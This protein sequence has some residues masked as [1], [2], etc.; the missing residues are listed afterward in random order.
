M[1]PQSIGGVAEFALLDDLAPA[2]RIVAGRLDGLPSDGLDGLRDHLAGGGSL[3]IA[4]EPGDAVAAELAGAAVAREHPAAEWFVTLEACPE[5]IRLDRETPVSSTLRTLTPV[6]DAVSVAATTNIAM[7]H[8]PVITVRAVGAGRV[9]ASGIADLERLVAHPTLGRFVGR[10]MRQGVPEASREIGVAIV[11]YGPYGGM[12]YAHGL[13][14]AETDGLRLVASAD[15]VPKRLA[16]AAVDFPDIRTYADATSLVH[17]D[18]VEAVIVATPPS[19]HAAIALDLLRAGRHVVL[20]KPMCLTVAEADQL[21]GEADRANRALTVHQSRRW[22]RDFLAL[23]AVVSARRIGEV[24]N[25]E[26]FVGGFDHP[27]RLWHSDELI[28]GGA[29]FDWGSHH[30]DWILRL[31]G[32]PPARVLASAHKRAWHDVTNADQVTVWMQ[33]PD[34]REAT[35]RQSDLSAIRRPKFYVQGTAGTIEGTYRPLVTEAI[36]PGRGYTEHH[37]HH[38]EAPVTLRIARY[39]GPGQLSEALVPPALGAGWAFHRNLA[40]HLLLGEPLAVPPSESR[41]V[42]AV[43]EAAHRSAAAG[44]ALVDLG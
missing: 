16:A 25:I 2:G 30:V 10:L 33:W 35:F 9:V 36:E 18:A 41:A 28:S 5:A 8:R 31:Y 6:A 13:A 19:S 12:G 22:D 20:E 27:C 43:L 39:D 26:T 23:E 42:V 4:P 34:G 11:G 7:R 37:E 17:D 1:D 15:T 24:F 32:S 38:A 21:I 3:L 14:C 40:D 29:I 44:G